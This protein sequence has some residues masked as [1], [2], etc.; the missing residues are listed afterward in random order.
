MI[1]LVKVK[2]SFYQLCKQY[3]VDNE[4]LF[5]ENGRPCVLLV[6]LRYKNR[7]QDFVIPLRS[8]ISHKTPCVQYFSLPPNSCTKKNR[9]H[10]VHYIKLFPIDRK[11]LD[12]YQLFGDRYY[13][14]ILHILN[15]FE[16]D[17]VKSC[18]DYLDTCE[19]GNKHLMTPDIDG[20]LEMLDDLHECST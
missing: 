3:G 15:T 9:K 4:L 6:K 12:K 16:K 13:M 5:N 1:S 14:N 18:Q 2:S 11:Y 17:I 10:G 19:N 20:I 8:N 7:L